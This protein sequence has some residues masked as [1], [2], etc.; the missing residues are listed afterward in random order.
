M[1]F[2]MVSI[3]TTFKLWLRCGSKKAIWQ[4]NPQTS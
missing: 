1:T 3:G 4:A 2:E